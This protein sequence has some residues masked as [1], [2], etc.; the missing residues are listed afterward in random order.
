M[1]YLNRS[2]LL[3]G[4][5]KADGVHPAVDW[6]A[7]SALRPLL[8]SA[9]VEPYDSISHALEDASGKRLSIGEIQPLSQKK[10][11]A[12]S[13]EWF[14]SSAMSGVGSLLPFVISG[15]LTGGGLRGASSYLGLEGRAASILSSNRLAQISGAGI[16]AALK[17]PNEGE[18]R[19]GNAV[20][21]MG[22]FAIFDA[23]NSLAGIS[24]FNKPGT[25]AFA[26][27]SAIR[28]GTGF[29]GGASQAE[30]SS[31]VARQKHADKELLLQSA[32]SGASLNIAMGAYHDIA[33]NGKNTD[34][35][36]NK[37]SQ[38]KE[39]KASER[40]ED[41]ATKKIERGLLGP[42]TDSLNLARSD[43][44][45]A[46]S[47]IAEPKAEGNVVY[48]VVDSGF[49]PESLPPRENILGTWDPTGEG[50]FN[51]PLQHGSV[52][53]SKLRDSDPGAK[54]MLIRA[55]DSKSNLA[56]T[57]FENGQISKAGWTEAYLDAVSLAKQLKLPSV[58]NCS[59]GEF[60]HAMDG[61]GWESYQLSHAIGEGKAGH[62]VVAAA[63]P[64]NGSA[65]HAS[66]IVEVSG[67]S[68]VNIS[69]NG[70]AAFN[71]WM[72]KDAPRDW[73]LSVYEGNQKIHHVDG[74]HLDSNF[75]NN[76]Q[77]LTFR[78]HIEGAAT[79]FVLSRTGNDPRPLPFDFYIQEGKATFLD[80]VN[81]QLISEPAIFPSVVAVG[82]RNLKYSPAQEVLEQK[83]NVLLPGE[84]PV[85]FRTPEIS[86]AIAQLLKANPNLDSTQV[87]NLLGKFPKGK[88]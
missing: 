78:S 67:R 8:N 72:G 53:L 76:R 38:N 19:L 41:P 4:P 3:D 16:Y 60:T 71:L 37:S 80:H 84:G 85:S 28:L 70:E 77:Q 33:S 69:Q 49:S 46:R 81:P 9:L 27:R 6:L 22:A 83:P 43:N 11:Q 10:H 88:N 73:N 24:R 74:A 68:E 56:Q 54:F 39:S 21:T 75:W 29:L 59:F 5:R 50:V 47:N 40:T 45:A 15:K 48:I 57:R 86:Y 58:A 23:G 61:T 79:R 42:S 36:R 13:P 82:V 32:V 44:S 87:Q 25:L 17:R 2:S 64:G 18:T 7:D 26:E 12:Y 66:G 34:A 30:L 55:Y 35:R 52:V 63:G 65:R 51:D 1:E 62:I 20:G 31:L 14:V